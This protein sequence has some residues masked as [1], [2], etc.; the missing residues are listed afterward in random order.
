MIGYSLD[1]AAV[2][3]MLQDIL[4]IAFIIRNF[5]KLKLYFEQ[6]EFYLF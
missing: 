4:F 1:T 2:V 6:H 5:L 3:N